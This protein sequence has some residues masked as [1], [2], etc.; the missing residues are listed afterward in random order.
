MDFLLIIAGLVLL[1]AAGDALVRGAVALSLRLGVPAV[2]VGATVVAF[3]T[4]APELL[5]SVQ[6]AIEGSPGIALGNVV[7]SNIANVWLVLGLPALITPIAG[8]G[9]DAHR[10]LWFMLLSTAIFTVLLLPGTIWWWGGLVLIGVTALMVADSIRHSMEMRAINGEASEEIAELEDVDPDMPSWKILG[11]IT[12]SLIGLPL[13]AQL[14]IDGARGIASEFGVSETVI[15]LT[16][17][18][19]GTSLPE[20]A[21][22]LMAAIRAQADVA[23][24]NVVGSNIFNVTFIIGAAALVGPMEVPHEILWRDNWI[25][26]AA[27]LTLAPFVL[28]CR[29]ICRVAGSIFLLLYGA[30]LVFAVVG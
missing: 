20:L 2:I 13:G 1:L 27:A 16:L 26:V 24:G 28:T 4:S 6:A 10:N 23:I 17:V 9:K 12:A 19:L 14:L 29:R 22:T 3:G 7:G 21:T 5:I 15:G 30:F 8:C 25:M 11:L 18:A